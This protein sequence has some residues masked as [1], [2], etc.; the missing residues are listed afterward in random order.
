LELHLVVPI[1][2][3]IF[4]NEIKLKQLEIMKRLKEEV[5]LEKKFKTW[6]VFIGKGEHE[7]ITATLSKPLTTSQALRFF[8]AVGVMGIE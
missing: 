6:K 3:L 5:T 8:K 1:F 4:A 2:F 7:T